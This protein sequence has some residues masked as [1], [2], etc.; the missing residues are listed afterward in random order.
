ME[1]RK[2]SAR[3]NQLFSVHTETYHAGMTQSAGAV[4]TRDSLADALP[5]IFLA[6]L[7]ANLPMLALLLVPQLMRG[8]AGSETLLFIGSALYLALIAVA[9]TISPRVSVWTVPRAGVWTA[10]TARQTVHSIRRSHAREFWLRVAEWLL[11]FVLAQ[12]IGLFI[13]WLMPYIR[14]NP[15]FGAAG[16]PR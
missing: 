8:R 2:S 14:D 16:E 12:A 15:Q 9:L 3:A 10:R 13:A 1:V 4:S 11:L 6:T 7:V 5:K